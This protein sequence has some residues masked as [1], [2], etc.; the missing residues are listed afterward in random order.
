M[1][2][3]HEGLATFQTLRRRLAQLGVAST[4]DGAVR[5]EA[6]APAAEP[7]RLSPAQLLEDPVA[8][9][10]RVEAAGEGRFDAFL[11]GTQESRTLQF[12]DG[13]AVIHGTV[14]AVVRT[15]VDRRMTTWRHAVERALY[16]PRTALPDSWWQLLLAAGAPV[17]D[18]SPEAGGETAGHHPFTL[19]DAAIHRVQQDRERLET[20]L[21]ADW[22][23]AS[24]GTLLVDGSVGDGWGSEWPPRAIGLVKSHRTIYV[25]PAMLPAIFRLAQGERSAACRIG[26]TWRQPVVSWYLRMR[27]ATGRDPMWGLVRLEVPE[28]DGLLGD[29]SR[30][31]DE[32][33][34]WVLSESAPLSLPDSRWDKL[35]YGV[36]DCE[37]FL[38]A[39]V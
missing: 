39:V 31:V 8:P 37:R 30:R 14:A 18:T 3:E 33:S 6:L 23:Q 24:G 32:V 9:L 7:A 34:S 20:R 11:D 28:S 2:A 38:Q 22:R 19:R 1:C 36:H 16:A 13:V 10:R 35:V 5:L 17:V 25:E 21:A 27:D 15:R 12:V 4:A 29:L 26:S